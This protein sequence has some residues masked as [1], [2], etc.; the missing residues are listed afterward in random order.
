M[1][2]G[3]HPVPCTFWVLVSGQLWTLQTASPQSVVMS[4]YSIH[5]ILHWAKINVCLLMWA[6]H[7]SFLPLGHRDRLL[8]RTGYIN[9]HPSGKWKFGTLCL[10]IVENFQLARAEHSAQTGCRPFRSC[11]HKASCVPLSAVIFIVLLHVWGFGLP[12]VHVCSMLNWG[13]I[14]FP[15]MMNHFPQ[16]IH[17]A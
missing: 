9:G 1:K 15:H 13:L 6:F 4:D 7:E 16:A 5:V 2:A 17:P 3:G 12:R 10:K 8:C 14:F 11:A